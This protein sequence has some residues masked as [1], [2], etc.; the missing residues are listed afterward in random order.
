MG[1]PGGQRGRVIDADKKEAMHTASPTTLSHL[2]W[3]TTTYTLPK[4]LD[5]S[6]QYP[7]SDIAYHGI[8]AHSARAE[9]HYHG[10]YQWVPFVLFLQGIA[11]YL[12]HWL[13]KLVEG[14]RL[15]SLLQEMQL[16]VMDPEERRTRLA[17]LVQY[18]AQTLGSYNGYFF[19]FVLCELLNVANVFFNFFVINCFL[20]GRFLRYG[21]RALAFFIGSGGPGASPMTEVFP[22]LTKCNF[23][24]VGGSGSV[25]S[26]DSICVMAL[27]IL[28]EKI[29][30]LLWFWL[31]L[32][33]AASVLAFAWRVVMMSATA[34][35]V[36]MLQARARLA[37]VHDLEDLV[38]SVRL[39]D[40]FLLSLLARN[41]D[42]VAF[43]QLVTDLARAVTHG[44]GR[45]VSRVTAPSA[46]VGDPQTLI[47]RAVTHRS[48]ALD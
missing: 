6:D 26:I 34:M 10:Y 23:Q 18:L 44:Q 25:E 24:L 19:R 17:N 42:L 40:F 32:L 9:K 48:A 1:L 31:V 30:L 2:L 41:M 43:R 39:G 16:P 33:A 35:R 27:N 4:L 11:F 13:W 36:P 22:K 20:G 5:K 45:R 7:H 8:G 38:E 37:D 47:K 15:S 3:I 14:R 28:N 12:P 21:P 46:G 29:Y